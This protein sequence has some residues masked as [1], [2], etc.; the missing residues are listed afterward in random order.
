MNKRQTIILDLLEQNQ[1]ITVGDLVTRFSVSEATIRRD[2]AQLEGKNKLIRTFGGAR[3]LTDLS[4]AAQSFNERKQKNISEKQQIVE[5]AAKLITPGMVIALDNGTTTWMIAS[6]LKNRT[7]LTVVT[8]SLAIVQTLH[9]IPD[10]TIMLIGGKFRLRNIDFIGNSTIE[11]FKKWHTNIAFISGDAIRLRRGIY[12]I[13]EGSAAIISAMAFSS[14]MIVGV[15]D[16]TK[17]ENP[18]APCLGIKAEELDLLITNECD[19]IHQ[20]HVEDLPYKIIAL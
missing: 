17:I 3:I 12:K 5:E 6:C 19:K 4:I 16:Y 11:G 15:L 18:N 10:I 7:P 1:V 13:E 9:N 8:S 20:Q 14:D 2:L